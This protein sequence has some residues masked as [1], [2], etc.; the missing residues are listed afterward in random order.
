MAAQCQTKR[1]RTP[2]ISYTWVDEGMT[3]KARDHKILE[4]NSRAF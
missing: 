3:T 4:S 1:V 2:T